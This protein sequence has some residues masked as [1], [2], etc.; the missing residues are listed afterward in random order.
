M[1]SWDWVQGILWYG[2]SA[3]TQPSSPLTAF[4]HTPSAKLGVNILE[5]S[6]TCLHRV[7]QLIGFNCIF[8]HKNPMWKPCILSILQMKRKRADALG[9]SQ[10]H[11][12]ASGGAEL[13]ALSCQLWGQCSFQHIAP[14]GSCLF[15]CLCVGYPFLLFYIAEISPSFKT[16]QMSS[17]Q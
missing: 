4:I 8:C 6:V 13:Q 7:G 2:T 14:L 16:N 15:N 5:Y 11:S 10:G 3:H 12:G 9:L 1:A 17:T